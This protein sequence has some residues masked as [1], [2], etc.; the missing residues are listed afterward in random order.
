MKK[1]GYR[2]LSNC[3]LY[4]AAHALCAN[5][6]AQTAAPQVPAPAVPD[7][8]APPA[9][10]PSSVHPEKQKLPEPNLEYSNPLG[11]EF[12]KHLLADQKSIWS[13]PAHLRW[14]DASWLFPLAA[15]TGGFLAS[16]RAVPP[17]LT[18]DQKKLNRYVSFSNY[19]LYSMIG[20]GGGLY[21]WS[22]L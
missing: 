17:A 3:F 13:S 16:D 1:R 11:T 14:A 22:K 9:P 15:A 6:V 19:G 20:A 21:L 5:A 8:D 7:A 18:T 12:L 2:L 10:Q 4:A